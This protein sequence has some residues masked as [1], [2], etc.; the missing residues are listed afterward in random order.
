MANYTF[1]PMT[2]QEANAIADWHYEEP[3][4]F[5]DFRND[6]EDLEE[7][8]NSKARQGVYYSVYDD[9]NR[10]IGFFCYFNDSGT[11]EMGLG[12]RPDLTGKGLGRAFIQA[13]LNFAEEKFNPS[14]FSLSVAVFN[15]R[16]LKVYER[17]GFKIEKTMMVKS[18]GSVYPF[19]SMVL[20]ED[21]V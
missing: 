21:K 14:M 19:Y 5:Y 2:D 8:L 1:K 9:Q 16:A 12:L 17:V 4:S 3:Y 10:L 20:T 18:N 7:L 6:E 15:E 13:G 11:I